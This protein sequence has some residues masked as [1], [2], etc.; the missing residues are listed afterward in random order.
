MT[1]IIT[2]A[3]AGGAIATVFAIAL[4]VGITN[5]LRKPLLDVASCGCRLRSTEQKRA[6]QSLVDSEKMAQA[7]VKTALDAFVQTDEGG[8]ILDWSPHAEALIGW[9][10]SEA[11]GRS[12]VDWCFR[13]RSVPRTGSGSIVSWARSRA[14]P[15]AGGMRRRCCTRTA[16]N[17]SPKCR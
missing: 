17:S 14:A 3:L 9:T 16:A 4:A 7:I 6:H 11:V 1:A 5:G 8:I 15:S 12:V 2:A 13:N 10:R